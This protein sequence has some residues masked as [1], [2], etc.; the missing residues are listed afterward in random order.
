MADIVTITGKDKLKR[1]LERL[2]EAFKAA[3][4]AAMTKSANDM[5]AMMKRLVPVD[6][7]NLR[8]SIG[9]TFGEPPQ[10]SRIITQTKPL[11][12]AGDIRLTVYAGNDEAF[13]ARWVEFGTAPH[14]LGRRQGKGKPKTGALHP[15]SKAQP[16]FFPA[17]RIHA[18]KIKSRLTRALNK[19]AKRIAAE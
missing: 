9:W 16:F 8:N 13:Y 3:A 11:K 12:S 7:G 1:K 2:P 19:E 6:D 15:G 10:G 5:V 17:Y 14:T 18:K 4:I